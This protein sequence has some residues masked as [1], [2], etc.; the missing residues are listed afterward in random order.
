M[1]L[2]EVAQ[3]IEAG[4]RALDVTG[5]ITVRAG[6]A[7]HTCWVGNPNAIKDVIIDVTITCP[8]PRSGRRI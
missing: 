4:M 8:P 1:K 2:D 3:I 6:R 5:E 7:S